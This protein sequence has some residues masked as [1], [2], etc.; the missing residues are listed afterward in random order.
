MN[1]NIII[2][3]TK[4]S[5]LTKPFYLIMDGHYKI[6][7][8][9]N[10]ISTLCGLFNAR[11]SL[12]CKCLIVIIIILS[13]FQHI[14][15]SIA[16]FCLESFVRTQMITSYSYQIQIIAIYLYHHHVLLPAQISL[17]LSRHPSLSSIAPER[18]SRLY[19]VSVQ[20]CC[21]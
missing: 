9:V 21:I 19:L 20:S 8:L 12:I 5:F 13:I 6:C 1:K 3:L 18:S 14:F 7:S 10:G 17:T 15:F 11:V 16:L 4:C 2:F